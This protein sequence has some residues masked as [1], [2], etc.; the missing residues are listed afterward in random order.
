M[1]LDSHLSMAIVFQAVLEAKV[2][3]HLFLSYCRFLRQF[4]INVKNFLL[5]YWRLSI[6]DRED[7]GE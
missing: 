2:Y 7:Q 5:Q 6:L 3:V 1:F 4:Q